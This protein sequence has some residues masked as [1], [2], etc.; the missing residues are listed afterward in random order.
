[1]NSRIESKWN[2]RQVARSAVFMC[3]TASI[4]C[5]LMTTAGEAVTNLVGKAAW[6]LPYVSLVFAVRSLRAA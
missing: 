6:Y 3:L 1:M 2:V 5:L 4:V